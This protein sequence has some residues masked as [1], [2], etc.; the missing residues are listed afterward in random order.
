MLF[1]N[2]LLKRRLGW[3]LKKTRKV[4]KAIVQKEIHLKSLDVTIG[5][6]SGSNY[7]NPQLTVGEVRNLYRIEDCPHR[8]EMMAA[9]VAAHHAYQETEQVDRTVPPSDNAPPV[10]I[11]QQKTI[12]SSPPAETDLDGYGY[13]PDDW[14]DLEVA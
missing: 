3:D 5:I 14:G 1:L 2:D 12:Q 11:W 8:A 9:I 4:T 10:V 13:A 6:L 7:E